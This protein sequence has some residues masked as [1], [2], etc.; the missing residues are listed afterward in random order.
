MGRMA[1]TRMARQTRPNL[2]TD[3]ITE[4]QQTVDLRAHKKT[5][6]C[7]VGY[8][9]PTQRSSTRIQPQPRANS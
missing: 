5:V 3:A 8:V 2:E 1:T 9:G 4:V 6:E 7:G